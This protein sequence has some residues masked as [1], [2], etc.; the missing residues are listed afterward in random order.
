MVIIDTAG[1]LHNK[2][3]LMQELS[4]I[5]RVID[6]ELPGAPHETLLVLDGTKVAV[7]SVAF[8]KGRP[9]LHVVDERSK[10]RTIGAEF[11]PL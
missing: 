10:P 11:T 5:H 7:L 4:K 6:K 2:S 1:R 3:H 8:R 9:R